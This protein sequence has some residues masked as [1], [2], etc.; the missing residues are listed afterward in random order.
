M[1]PFLKIVSFCNLINV[2]TVTFDQLIG[3][4]LNNIIFISF[5]LKSCSS[6]NPLKMYKTFFNI[7]IQNCL[8]AN[9]LAANQQ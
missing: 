1:L 6:N 2:F 5:Q 3:F 4:L 9:C 8:A 7:D